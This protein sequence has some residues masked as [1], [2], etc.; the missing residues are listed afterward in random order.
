MGLKSVLLFPFFPTTESSSLSPPPPQAP[1]PAFVVVKKEEEE[2]QQQEEEEGKEGAR[3]RGIS[4]TARFSSSSP[5][6]SLI[7]KY[8]PSRW[9]FGRC[10]CGGGLLEVRQRE[11]LS[12]GGRVRHDEATRGG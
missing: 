5:P 9:W 11:R 7:Y 4:R 8:I 6:P 2:G 10:G 1:F 12:L 3:E